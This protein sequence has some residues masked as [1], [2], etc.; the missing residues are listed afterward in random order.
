MGPEVGH[1]RKEVL[2]KLLEV[3]EIEIGRMM[4][5]DGHHA[6]KAAKEGS[7]GVAFGS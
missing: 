1:S 2:G 4:L 7:R 5:N 6:R 3:V